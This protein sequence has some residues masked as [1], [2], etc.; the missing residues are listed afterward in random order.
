MR[1]LI[2]PRQNREA[3]EAYMATGLGEQI[4]DPRPVTPLLIVRG[5]L[6]RTEGEL[7]RAVADLRESVARIRRYTDRTSAG[8][9]GRLLLAET[10]HELGRPDDAIQEAREALTI[11]RAWGAPGALGEAERLH[12]LLL[13][14]EGSISCDRLPSDWPKRLSVSAPYDLGAAL[15]C[16]GRRR[17]CR[18]HLREGLERAEQ[19]SAD[20]LTPS[21][22]RIVELAAAGESN[23]RIAQA[24]FVTVKTVESHLATPTASSASARGASCPLR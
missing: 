9:D 1:S 13:G 24:L 14:G 21:E 2:E 15:R 12:G 7:D 17:E 10:L 19:R 20:P 6:R 11:A 22:R 3:Q 16:A 5:E 18:E 4:P 8:L 23:P